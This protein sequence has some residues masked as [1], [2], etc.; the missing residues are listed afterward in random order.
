M[1]EK[2]EARAARVVDG[3]ELGIIRKQIN[4]GLTR[5]FR[6]RALRVRRALRLLRR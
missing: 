4:F 1:D 3:R 5:A 6:S 2:N